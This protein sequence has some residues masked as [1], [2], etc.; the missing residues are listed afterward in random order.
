ML[1]DLLQLLPEKPGDGALIIA[2]I[3]AAF[4][5]GLWIAGVK[6][7]RPLV[8]LVTVLLGAVIGMNLPKWFNW[9]ISG[10]G[11]AVGGAVLLGVSGFVLHRMWVGI[12]LGCVLAFWTAL[13]M[14][15]TMRDGSSWS[16]PACDDST[17]WWS[18]LQDVWQIVPPNIARILPYATGVALVC[19]VASCILWPKLTTVVSW[20]A[21]G[22]TMCVSL[23]FTA[24]SITHKEWL[25]D[26]PQRTWIQLLSL[27]GLWFVGA[28]VQWKLAP[29]KKGAPKSASPA[30]KKQKEA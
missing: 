9:S 20:S 28:A 18:Y 4:G 10:A 27:A 13:V 16:W 6:V 2:M 14:W 1:L 7:S 21:I 23:A 30:E 25:T 8:T 26:A 19:G 29:K 22:L 24:I 3:G 15:L 12:G 5:A 11:P 17:T